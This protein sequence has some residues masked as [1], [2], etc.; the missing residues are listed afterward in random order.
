MYNIFIHNNIMKNIDL[1]KLFGSKCRYKIL[2][3]Y[4]LEYETWNNEWFHMRAIARETWEQINS[5]KRELDNL[6][7]LWLFK[8]KLEAKKKIYFLNTN[9][10]LFDELKILFVKAYNPLESVK[11]FFLKQKWL[12]VVILNE[13]LRSKMLDSWKTILDIFLIWDI[14][15]NELNNFLWSTFYNKKIKFAIISKEDFKNRVEYWDKLISNILNQQWNIYLVDNLDI[16]SS[17]KIK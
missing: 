5:V 4:F 7:N 13:N 10:E 6:Y 14:D 16:R 2:E 1:T 12:D 11:K 9:F 8:Y 17:F 15:K 3:K